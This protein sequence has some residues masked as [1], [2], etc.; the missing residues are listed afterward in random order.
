MSD[1]G[2]S[3]CVCIRVYIG[4]G[5]YRCV[6][7]YLCVVGHE[8]LGVCRGGVISLEGEYMC[9]YHHVYLLICLHGVGY[10]R[11]CESVWV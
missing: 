10:E 5:V 6:W 3:A 11:A 1:W 8:S 7:L 9:A 4:V 2:A